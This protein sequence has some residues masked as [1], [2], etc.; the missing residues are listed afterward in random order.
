MTLLLPKVMK[1]GVKVF[2]GHFRMTFRKVRSAFVGHFGFFLP[3]WAIRRSLDLEWPIEMNRVAIYWV[4]H[5]QLR[6]IV[7]CLEDATAFNF[8][9]PKF[10]QLPAHNWLQN[11]FKQSLGFESST[12][13]RKPSFGSQPSLQL[14]AFILANQSAQSWQPFNSCCRCCWQPSQARALANTDRVCK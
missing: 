3:L 2:F 6:K 12:F 5:W 4:A 13:S 14:F 10:I 7:L 8:W 9:L 1:A 11:I